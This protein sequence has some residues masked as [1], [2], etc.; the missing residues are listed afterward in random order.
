MK[1]RKPAKIPA[2]PVDLAAIWQEA[3]PLVDPETPPAIVEA[4]AIQIQTARQARAL[5]QEHGIVIRDARNNGVEH[6]A[7]VIER[8]AQAAI[9]QILQTWGK[10]PD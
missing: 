8:T 10:T 1:K 4:L 3:Q 7:L 2:L 9:S 5:V 6:P